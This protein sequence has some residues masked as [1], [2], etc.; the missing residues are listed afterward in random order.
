MGLSFD[1][2]LGDIAQLGV[3]YTFAATELQLTSPRV[4]LGDV[5]ISQLQIELLLQMGEPDAVTRPFVQFFGG[6]TW[7][8][9]EEA[10]DETRPSFGIGGGAKHYLASRKWGFRFQGRWITTFIEENESTSYMGPDQFTGVPSTMNDTFTPLWFW[11]PRLASS[12]SNS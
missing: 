8:A 10:E 4:P 7:F 9:A 12:D 2:N 1:V 3:L 11:C 6:G 5:N